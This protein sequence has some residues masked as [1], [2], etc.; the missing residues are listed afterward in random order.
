MR[1]YILRLDDASDYMDMEKWEYMTKLLDQYDVKPIFG[2]IPKNQDI[3]FLEKYKKNDSFWD[4][5]HRRIEDGWIPAMHGYEHR[6]E[7][8][9]SAGR[10]S[11][12]AELPYKMQRDKIEVG[13]AILRE[14]GVAPKIFFAPSHTFDENTL[15]ALQDVTPIRIISDT[16]A[17]D[18]YKK[19]DFWFVPQQS[20]RV[21]WQP[22]P[23][24][25]F[26]YHPN[27][28]SEREFEKL[29]KAL[30]KY[31]KYFVRFRKELL[32]NRDLNCID[33]GLRTMY[34]WKNTLLSWVVE[35]WI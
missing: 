17:Y 10:K 28:T 19:G 34:F 4:W 33:R 21:S 1:K 8:K 23:L 16:I 32:K 6:Y 24:V 3:V 13:Y 2:I 11:E 26:C 5:V 30:P 27:T 7:S 22:F 25:T 31:K 12:F 9:D 18:V 35:T 20:W 15:R 29:R 14:H